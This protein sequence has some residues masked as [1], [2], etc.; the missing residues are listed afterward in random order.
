MGGY[1]PAEMQEKILEKDYES[2]SISLLLSWPDY[3]AKG[4]FGLEC[5]KK[6][7]EYQ[8]SGEGIGRLILIGDWGERSQSFSKEFQREVMENLVF[9]RKMGCV[10]LP[11]WPL[12]KEEIMVFR[13]L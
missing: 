13:I 4:T 9:E 1:G 8:K 10:E 6:W 11:H 5:L 12:S 3:Q 2:E 7:M